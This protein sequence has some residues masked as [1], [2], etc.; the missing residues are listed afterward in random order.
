MRRGFRNWP[1]KSPEWKRRSQVWEIFLRWSI[2]L[3]R[4]CLPSQGYCFSVERFARIAHICTWNPT[5]C[6]VVPRR[7][8]MPT[9]SVPS[10]R[11]HTFIGSA[12]KIIHRRRRCPRICAIPPASEYKLAPAFINVLFRSD[13]RLISLRDKQIDATVPVLSGGG[14]NW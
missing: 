3:R 10:E 1:L 14:R 7:F 11:H 6:C 4:L 12:K 5:S 9:R 8:Q 2:T 13:K